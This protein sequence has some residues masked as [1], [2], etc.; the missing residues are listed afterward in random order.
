[1]MIRKQKRFK[2]WLERHKIK[3]K[4][5]F[6]LKLQNMKILQEMKNSESSHRKT[7]SVPNSSYYGGN[8]PSS[9]M[10]SNLYQV[11]TDGKLSITEE[12]RQM[13]MRK[14]ACPQ[15]VMKESYTNWYIE[16]V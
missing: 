15:S 14:M 3:S 4:I 12:G 9:K 6:R 16:L 10:N 1:M 7:N 13:V 5:G 8:F 11:G 2:R